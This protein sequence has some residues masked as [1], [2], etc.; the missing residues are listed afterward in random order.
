MYS[1]QNRNAQKRYN[2]FTGKKQL[3]HRSN[4]TYRF[5]DDVLFINNPEFEKYLGQVYP[6]DFAIKYT[7]VRITSVFA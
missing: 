6:A 2:L 5:I 4:L 3:A 1:V 7:I